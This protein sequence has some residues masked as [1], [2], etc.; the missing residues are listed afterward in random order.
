MKRIKKNFGR[1]LALL[2]ACVSVGMIASAKDSAMTDVNIAIEGSEKAVADT[3]GDSQKKERT[4]GVQTGDEKHVL[5]Y[6]LAAGVAVGIGGMYI[7]KKKRKGLLALLAVFAS[8]FFMNHSVYAAEGT[9]NVNVTIPSSISVCFDDTGENSISEFAIN[10]QSMVPITIDKVKVRECNEWKLCDAGETIPIDT[11]M[12]A[13][14]FENQCLKAEDN[15]LN[16]SIAEGTNK[17]CD[18]HVKRGA[19]TTSKEAETALQLEFGYTIGK[20]QFQIRFDTNGSTQSIP[21]QMVYNGESAVLPSAEREGYAFEGWEDSEG[22]LYTNQYVMPIGNV[23]LTARWREEVAYAIYVASDMSLRFI[24]TAEP[25]AVGSTYNGMTVSNVFTGFENTAYQTRAEVPW[26][27]GEWYTQRNVKK[28]I[29]EDKIQPIST[30]HWFDYM[31]N[32]EYLDLTKLD[33]SK[34]TNMKYMF[35]W[36]GFNVKNFTLKGVDNFDVSNVTD[37]TYTFAYT[38]RD[39]S[40]V[41]VDLS[42]WDVS[43]VCCMLE[44]FAGMGYFSTTFGLGDL[45]KWNVANVTNMQRMFQ[46]TGYYASWSVDCRSWDVSKVTNHYHFDFDVYDKVAAPYWVY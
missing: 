28:V 40:S 7:V 20:K 6:L 43:K 15:T 11:K 39:A 41:V 33:T 44:M 18:I 19:W 21:A 29:V 36:T 31:E 38:A 34:V 30:A 12:L 10:N 26:Y 22:N 24:R 46:Q 16:I 23:T 37:M 25:I 2:I 9:E 8:L 4:G 17:S 27:D 13:F 45:S 32:C 14:T 3:D 35:S 5:G 42:S 1:I